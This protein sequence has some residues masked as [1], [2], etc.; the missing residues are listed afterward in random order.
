MKATK[1]FHI[2][3]SLSF[4][5]SY[6]T[7]PLLRHQQEGMSLLAR[8]RVPFFFGLLPL[9]KKGGI[10]CIK[11]RGRLVTGLAFMPHPWF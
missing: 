9:M 6:S 2:C 1:S 7:V 11:K 4:A 3:L 10:F 5:M 8:R